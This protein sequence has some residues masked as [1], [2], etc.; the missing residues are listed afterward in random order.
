VR[1][2]DDDVFTVLGALWDLPP[3]HALAALLPRDAPTLAGY[4]GRLR[5]F[6]GAAP[7]LRAGTVDPAAIVRGEVV[8]MGEGSAIEA[9]AIIHESCRLV[10]GARSRIRSGA[11][12]RDDV[13]VGPDCLVGVHCEVFRSVVLGPQ[14][15]LAHFVVLGDSV[16]G[17]EVVVA[18]NVMFA[19]TMLRKGTVPLRYRGRKVDSRRTH[20]GALVGDGVRFGASTTLSPGC[21]VLPGLALPPQVLLHGVVDGARQRALMRRF[22]T[23]WAPRE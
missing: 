23:D 22:S 6:M 20:L 19:N 8:S 9:G 13:V 17:R 3:T 16:V 2:A 14:T 10:L 1:Q 5:D 21:I 11:V 15:V 12:L 7:R 18:G 4:H